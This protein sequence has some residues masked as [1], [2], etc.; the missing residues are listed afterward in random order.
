MNFNTATSSC[1]SQASC[2][3]ERVIQLPFRLRTCTFNSPNHAKAISAVHHHQSQSQPR[4]DRGKRPTQGSGLTAG[5]SQRQPGRRTGP[6]QRPNAERSK[7]RAPAAPS[8]PPLTGTRS[9]LGGLRSVRF[10]LPAESHPPPPLRPP[11]D[12]QGFGSS[13]PTFPSGL[14]PQPGHPPPALS[15]AADGAGAGLRAAPV[16]AVFPHPRFPPPPAPARRG[17]SL[18]LPQSGARCRRGPR[19]TNGRPAARTR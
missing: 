2:N 15:A 16:R 17:A 19:S 14:E 10:H 9:F 5:V 11:A 3:A 1:A 12:P 4:S 7:P 18:L 6:R 13:S 8:H